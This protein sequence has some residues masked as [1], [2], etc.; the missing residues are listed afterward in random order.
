MQIIP[1]LWPSRRSAR[2]ETLE[3]ESEADIGSGHLTPAVPR[4]G[5]LVQCGAVTF[6]SEPLF[7]NSSL[8]F[9]ENNLISHFAHVQFAG[10]RDRC[11]MHESLYMQAVLSGEVLCSNRKDKVSSLHRM[12]AVS[13]KHIASYS[14]TFTDGATPKMDPSLVQCTV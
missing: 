6:G 12:L 10:G 11:E 1:A 2:L 14:Q 8:L 5:P 4:A 7:F 9:R 13:D 3:F